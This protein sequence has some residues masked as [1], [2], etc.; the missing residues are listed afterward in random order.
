MGRV[1][2]GV[3]PG[4]RP[5]AVKAIRAELA[6]DPEFRSRF[7]R[8]VA[9]ARRVSGVYT[10]QVVDADVDGPV[11][12]MATAYVPGPSLAEAVDNHGPVPDGLL[13]ALAAGLAESLNAIHAA[14]VV[15]RDLKP[16]NVL[17]AEDGPRV[18]DFGISRAAESSTMLTQ[19][20]LVVGSPGFRPP[21]QGMGG[22]VGPPSDVFNLGAVLAFAATGEGPFGTGTTAALLYRV[23][24]GEPDLARVPPRVRPLI[25]RCLA[26]DPAQRPTAS[27]LLSEVGALQP[28]GNW[29]P[30]SLTRTFAASAVAGFG[31]SRS[32]FAPTGGPG[33]APSNPGYAP[34]NPGYAPS[35]PGYAP[36]NA[37]YAPSSPGY[38]PAG[39]GPAAYAAPEPGLTPTRTTAAGAGT[40]PTPPPGYTPPTPPPG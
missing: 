17:L 3:S 20:G 2:L 34:S 1:Y 13:L 16:S 29:L 23:A 36:S 31:L 28:D 9:S 10:A 33:Y 19:A 32:G 24:H 18:I 27:G 5:V 8:E 14:G 6:A 11:A 35:N 25:E 15:H 4:G 26:K 12:W 40:L 38:P 39:A 7:G 22:E 37:G 30:D 21:E